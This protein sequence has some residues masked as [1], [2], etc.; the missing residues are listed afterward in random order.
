MPERLSADQIAEGMRAIPLW[1]VVDD[2][3]VRQ[4]E[5]EDFVAALG[6]I[7]QVGA[8]SVIQRLGFRGAK[9]VRKSRIGARAVDQC[10]QLC[11]RIGAR[12]TAV[13]RHHSAAIPTEDRCGVVVAMEPQP[14][15]AK[16]GVKRRR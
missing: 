5:F 7:A 14:G 12:L 16:L 10:L 11:L 9:P 2:R 4:F 3:I 8:L 15:A 1:D 6:F 13:R